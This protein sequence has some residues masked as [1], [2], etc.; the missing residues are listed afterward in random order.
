[1]QK[2]NTETLSASCFPR[3]LGGVLVLWGSCWLNVARELAGT[4]RVSTELVSA[5]CIATIALGIVPWV[6]RVK[7]TVSAE[8]YRRE[9]S[10]LG[11]PLITTF[12]SIRRL[13][14]VVKT[15]GRVLFDHGR[16]PHFTV[17]LAQEAGADIYLGGSRNEMEMSG[18]LERVC[19]V[20][21]LPSRETVS[22]ARL[23]YEERVTPLQDSS[24][25]SSN[26][27]PNS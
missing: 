5:L 3:A 1:M 2:V 27:E 24:S 8:G 26:L 10:L 19:Q 17:N 18:L 16:P 11:F 7:A 14:E 20:T 12:V 23:R 13:K 25:K 15:K 21:G 6:M 4:L 22:S 9:W